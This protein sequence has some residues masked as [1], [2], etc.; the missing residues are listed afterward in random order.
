MTNAVKKAEMSA[1]VREKGAR[2]FP[3]PPPLYYG[4]AFAGGMVLHGAVPLEVQARPTSAVVGAAL[5]I[6]GLALDAAGVA[7]VIA[8]RTTIVPHRP[9]SKLITTGVYRFSRNPMYTGLAIMVAGGA[10]L[11]GTW[12]PVVL[13][14]LAVLAVRQ[15]AIGPEET[16]LAE[17]YGSIYA[18]YQH[19]VRRWL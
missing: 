11:A 18:D 13:L 15:L 2:V 6:A 16:Y 7:A 5:L 10:L 3:I 9:V 12:W 14:P 17:R 1:P 4:A 8:H 19:R